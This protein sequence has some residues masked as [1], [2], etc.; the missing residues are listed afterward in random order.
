MPITG[1]TIQRGGT[2]ILVDQFSLWLLPTLVAGWRGKARTRRRCD[3]LLRH[4]G[5]E[6]L[7][8]HR[9]YAL[10]VNGVGARRQTAASAR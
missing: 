2:L 3:R 8:W 6:V 9:I 10:I 5:L 1:D 4:C 7:D